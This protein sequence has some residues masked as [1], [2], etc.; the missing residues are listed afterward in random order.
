VAHWSNYDLT[1]EFIGAGAQVRRAPRNSNA[2]RIKVTGSCCHGA[3]RSQSLHQRVATWRSS[4]RVTGVPHELV[5]WDDLDQQLDDAPCPRGHDAQSEALLR[6]LRQSEREDRRLARPARALRA[7]AGQPSA[8]TA[9]ARGGSTAAR[10][11]PPPG[12]PTSRAHAPPRS[13]S[14]ARPRGTAA[15]RRGRSADGIARDSAGRARAGAPVLLTTNQSRVNSRTRAPD[16]RFG[17]LAVAGMPEQQPSCGPATQC[18]A[19][20]E[21]PRRPR[22]VVRI[23]HQA[24]AT[25]PRSKRI[26]A[27]GCR[28]CGSETTQHRRVTRRD[29]QGRRPPA[30][31]ARL[32]DVVGGRPRPRAASP[33]PRTG[34]A[35]RRGCGRAARR[36]RRRSSRTPPRTM[37]TRSAS[38]SASRQTSPGLERSRSAAESPGDFATSCGFVGVQTPQET[39]GR[40]D[41]CTE[42]HG[43]ES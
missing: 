34:H 13:R 18:S 7:L 6:C 42:S 29:P 24:P 38:A 14:C 4:C 40:H 5:T 37:Q 25:P 36:A 2:Q 1:R 35:R 30:R 8:S 31:A 28:R 3:A 43:R 33:R 41:P 12:A 22:R 17:V 23:V 16:A 19:N 27:R 9:G 39:I 11:R 15:E 10:A 26:S 32:G 21:Q 20:P